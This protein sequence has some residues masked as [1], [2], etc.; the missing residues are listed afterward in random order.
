MPPE[1]T[2]RER[3]EF[4]ARVVVSLLILFAGLFVIFW[5]SYPDAII[6]WA[7]GTVGIVVGY[8]LR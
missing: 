8:W 1:F 2:E 6:K 7:I 5:G 3:W 4:G